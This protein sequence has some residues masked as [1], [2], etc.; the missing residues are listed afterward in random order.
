MAQILLYPDQL[1]PLVS[2]QDFLKEIHE[3]GRAAHARTIAE[4]K[5]N[6]NG[7]NQD[8]NPIDTAKHAR[9][10]ADA[11]DRGDD[12]AARAA[13]E[14]ATTAI[15]PNPLTPID[16]YAPDERLDGIR[17]R[18]RVLS[19]KARTNLSAAILR[20]VADAEA[21]PDGPAR[22]VAESAT[23][24][25]QAAV[26]RA[27]VAEVQGFEDE[28][29][30][31]IVMA[32]GDDGLLSE[33]DVGALRAAGVAFTLYLA[34][35]AFQRLP[36]KK[37]LLCGVP[38]LFGSSGSSALSVQPSSGLSVVATAVSSTLTDGPRTSQ[39]PTTSQTPVPV[40]R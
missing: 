7:S 5:E 29:G 35:S 3:E 11:A 40:V 32:A 37:K 39:A 20:A 14:K 2:L 27:V 30:Q 24:D 17:V 28:H 33:R 4:R 9:E 10:A 18:M 23:Q 13:L 16:P 34:A 19:D 15:G 6:G 22:M 8:A 31:P 1:G 36:A 21:A 26:V 38:S 25:A 12:V